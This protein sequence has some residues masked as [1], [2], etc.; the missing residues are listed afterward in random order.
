MS[1]IDVDLPTL[2]PGQVAAY[3]VISANRYTAVRCGR[4]F[5]KTDLLKTIAC[6]GAVKGQPIGWFAPEYKYIAEAYNE[7]VEMLEPVIK[8]QSKTDGVVRLITGGRIDFWSLKNNPRA[9]RSRKY[10]RVLVD[11]GAF[12]EINSD[13]SM[14]DVWEKAIKPTLVDL[15]GTAVVASNTNGIDADNFLYQIAGADNRSKY[16]FAD[17]HATTFDNPHLPREELDKLEADNHPLVFQQEYLAQFVDWSGVAFFSKDKMIVNGDGVP[18]PAR[19]DA[20]F[21]VIDSATKTGTK[22]DGTGCKYFALSRHPAGVA[23]QLVILDW[24][25]FQ[26][27][28]ALLEA[29]LPTVFTNLEE[30]AKKCGARSGS[31][32][33]FIEDKSSGMVLLQHARN[34]G[35]PA[36]EIDSKLTSVGKDERAI[37]VSGYV[38]RELVKYSKKA[39]DKVVT[40][41]GNTRNHSLAQVVGFRI[42]DPKARER[43]DDLL[44]CHC[45]GIALALGDSGGF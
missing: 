32:G 25:L 45:Y 20:V 12:T 6:D 3:S 17:F 26:I 35:W 27:E 31:L 44:D 29:W 4:R 13:V 1:V 24:E 42:G 7:I 37:S 23:Y 8:Q 2:H 16:G 30:M 33:A 21:A 40:Y 43:E 22:N 36:R 10:R 19:C 28:G 18:W 41:K 38:Y 15:G 9:G 14:M 39:Y 5:G 11:E 34:K